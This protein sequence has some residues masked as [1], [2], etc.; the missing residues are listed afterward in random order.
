MPGTRLFSRMNY[1]VL[2]GMSEI[3]TIHNLNDNQWQTIR[4]FFNQR[5]A[6]C[7]CEDTGNP[8]TG[9]IPDHLIAASDLGDM[10]FGNAVPACHDCNDKRGKKDWHTWLEAQFQAATA[11]RIERIEQYLHEFPYIQ[12]TPESRL[13][14]DELSEY[15]LLLQ[16][17]DSI[18]QRARLLKDRVHLR[19]MATQ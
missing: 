19:R 8:R 9:L 10:V 11:L 14:A 1:Q 17:W 3:I 2:R 7:N 13:T 4:S 16:E 6:F 18:W 5:C 12:P 15:N